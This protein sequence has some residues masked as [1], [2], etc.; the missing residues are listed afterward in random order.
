[1]TRRRTI[2]WIPLGIYSRKAILVSPDLVSKG[3]NLASF[4]RDPIPKKT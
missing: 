3:I 2:E 4:F 1:M